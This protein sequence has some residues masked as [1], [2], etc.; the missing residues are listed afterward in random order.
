ME[1]KVLPSGQAAKIVG[2]LNFA[3]QLAHGRFGRAFLRPL[4]RCIHALLQDNTVSEWTLR[5][6][7]WWIDV[8]R[9]EAVEWQCM[10][11]KT[12]SFQAR[13]GGLSL[14]RPLCIRNVVVSWTDAASTTRLISAVFFDGKK[15]EYTRM[16]APAQNLD[17]LVQRNDGMIGVLELLA[18]LLV[19]ET[20]KETLQYAR[21][22]AYIDND[23]VLYSI[24]NASSRASDVNLL[25]GKLWKSLH[26]LSTDLTA[27][28]VESKASIGDA[29]SRLSDEEEPHDL[30]YLGATFVKPRLPPFLFS[31]W[32]A[33]THHACDS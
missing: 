24:I 3:N 16:E 7:Q 25:V 23:G 32:A 5:V 28:R 6:I 18:V 10:I 30:K 33:P 27:F 9:Q 31:V 12:P 8:L 14:F 4:I 2:K 19:L 15:F 22:Q 29:P 17:N 26:T 13:P 21:W 11:I 1:N 20:W